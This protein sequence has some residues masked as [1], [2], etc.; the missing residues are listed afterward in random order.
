MNP[1]NI[2]RAPSFLKGMARVADLFGALDQYKYSDTT[3]SELL[4][5]D[6]IIAGKDLHQEMKRY[7]RKIA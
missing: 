6:W 2:F 5:R 1:S 4:K 3:D 7:E